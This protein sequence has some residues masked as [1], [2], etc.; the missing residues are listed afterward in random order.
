VNICTTPVDNVC[1]QGTCVLVG[2]SSVQPDG[3]LHLVIQ[4]NCHGTG[5]GTSGATYVA[6][7]V[8]HIVLDCA[9]DSAPCTSTFEERVHMVSQGSLPNFVL[10]FLMHV[11]VNA[12]G[13]VTAFVDTFSS[14]CQ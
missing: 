10:V 7:D 5:V 12:D 9:A 13:T 3:R 2:Q 6:S 8:S 4:M 1:I 11:T 14:A